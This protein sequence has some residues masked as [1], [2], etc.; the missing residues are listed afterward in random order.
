MIGLGSLVPA[1]F[2]FFFLV[3]PIPPLSAGPGVVSF[4]CLFAFSP[5]LPTPRSV[6]GHG[7]GNRAAKLRHG[8]V[9]FSC[10]FSFL[11]SS[12][13]RPPQLRAGGAARVIWLLSLW[14]RTVCFALFS[15]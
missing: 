1:F 10:S 8:T 9:G 5:V 13:R 2:F 12:C 14:H 15:S 7:P 6:L 4:V 3:L 11:L